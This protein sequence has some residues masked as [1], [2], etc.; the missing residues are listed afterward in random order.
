VLTGDKKLKNRLPHHGRLIA[1][2]LGGGQK[3]DNLA[4]SKNGANSCGAIRKC[5]HIALCVLFPTVFKRSIMTIF[6]EGMLVCAALIVLGVLAGSPLFIA[7]FASIPFETTSFAN[8]TSLGGASPPIY[9]LLL[10]LFI[11]SIAVRSGTLR[12]IGVV[13]STNAAVWISLILLAYTI[14]GSILFPRLFAGQ[15]SAFVPV[16]GV[17]TEVL[18]APVS[19]NITQAAYL[20]LNMFALLAFSVFLLRSENLAIVR[21][22]FFIYATVHIALGIADLIG[23]L[24]GTGDVLLPIRTASYSLLTDVE[25]SGYWR[26]VGGYSEASAYGGRSLQGLAFMFTYWRATQSVY[27][28]VL[29]LILL[30]LVLFSTSSTAYVGLAIISIPLLMSILRSVFTGRIIAQ[31]LLM[32]GIGWLMLT[33]I[34]AVHLYDERFF[35]PFTE[36]IQTM[37]LDK[38]TSTSAKERLYWN[39]KSIQSVYD[40]FGIG[41]GIGSSRS[42]SFV[43]AVLSQLGLIGTALVIALIGIVVRGMR[44]LRRTADNLEIFAFAS[45]ARALA[46]TLLVTGSLIG[47]TADPGLLFFIALATI[48]ACRFHV[49]RP[50]GGYR[51]A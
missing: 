38:P 25:Q 50:L 45:S 31:E 47:G 7:V 17:I 46:L 39:Q 32:L 51:A 49:A 14:A 48:L 6:I 33:A 41:I 18:L 16:K 37:V 28:L 40:T 8:L 36:L 29:A 43:I 34:L 2:V 30:G 20:S 42:S 24:A 3:T 27:A 19:G 35:E 12:N 21:R 22:G 23:K 10:L 13:F 4:K 9:T 5:Q 1:A 11:A 44:G 15:T 26:I